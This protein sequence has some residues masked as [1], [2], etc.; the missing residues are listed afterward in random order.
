MISHGLSLSRQLC[1]AVW[2]IQWRGQQGRGYDALGRR[3]SLGLNRS[4]RDEEALMPGRLRPADPDH[5]CE[6]GQPKGGAEVSDADTPLH[7]RMVVCMEGWWGLAAFAKG[8]RQAA[9]LRFRPLRRAHL[10]M[11]PSDPFGPADCQVARR[12]CVLR[13]LECTSVSERGL[14][15]SVSGWGYGEL[16]LKVGGGFARSLRS[17][18]PVHRR[19]WRCEPRGRRV[20]R[21]RLRRPAEGECGTGQVRP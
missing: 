11:R 10:P 6:P 8:R 3:P 1:R 16:R 21:P 9:N 4:S 17:R 2:S 18:A 19:A 5:G 20:V 15:G 14:N 12:R 7:G 13:R